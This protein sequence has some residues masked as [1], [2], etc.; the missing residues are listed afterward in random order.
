M[1]EY[2]ATYILAKDEKALTN[3]VIN[4]FCRDNRGGRR[5]TIKDLIYIAKL[6]NL[7]CDVPA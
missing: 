6:E 2:G 1:S 4:S 7:Y 3:F 5:D